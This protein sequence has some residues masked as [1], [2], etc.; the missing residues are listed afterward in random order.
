MIKVDSAIS[1]LKKSKKP[2][3]FDNIYKNIK[4]TLPTL[5]ESESAI[6]AEL[7]NALIGSFEIVRIK[8]QTFDLSANY[9]L[10]ELKRIE[11]LNSGTESLEKE[12]EA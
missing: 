2:Q 7:W 4:D 6:K 10:T 12:E 9:S 5:H 11:K 3:T 1:Y 8:E